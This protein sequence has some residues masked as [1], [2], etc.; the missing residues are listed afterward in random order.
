MK[1]L[2]PVIPSEDVMGLR[3][4]TMHENS[5]F[6]TKAFISNSPSGYF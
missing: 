1:S 5:L 6:G 2:L 4:A 3:P